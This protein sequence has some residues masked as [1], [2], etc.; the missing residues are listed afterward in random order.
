M[1]DA[2]VNPSCRPQIAGLIGEKA[3]TK[4]PVEYIDFA[5][6]FS[7]DLTSELPEHTGINDHA[8]ELVEADRFIRPSKSSAGASI[9]FD[10][11][12]DKSLR[13]CV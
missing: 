13:L 5:N 1:I 3:P 10:R 7:L 11:K 12:S 4:V 8:I 6:V 2:D 9:L